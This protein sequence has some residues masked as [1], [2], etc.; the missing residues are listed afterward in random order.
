[1]IVR[2]HVT[3]F[4]LFFFFSTESDTF[5]LLLQQFVFCTLSNSKSEA[6][7]NTLFRVG[8]MCVFIQL[9]FSCLPRLYHFFRKYLTGAVF[10][11]TE[12]ERYR[13]ITYFVTVVFSFGTWF[14]LILAV[15]FTMI[16]NRWIFKKFIS[17]NNDISPFLTVFYF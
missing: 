10:N 8:I 15:A 6:S 12:R 16:S 17:R 9:L 5:P 14:C 3:I 13:L 2:I 4:Y 11:C 1:M 7:I